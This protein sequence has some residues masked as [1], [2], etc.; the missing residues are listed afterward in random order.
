LIRQ[1]YFQNI[2]YRVATDLV[3]TDATM[4]KT[5]WLG[6]YPGLGNEH[7]D[8]ISEKLEEFFGVDF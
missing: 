6:I 7:L 8:F 5:L 1:P 3:N 2:G 4:N